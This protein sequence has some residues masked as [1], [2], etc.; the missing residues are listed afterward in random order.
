M[1]IVDKG[2]TLNKCTLINVKVFGE[3][4]SNTYS[5]GISKFANVV[6]KFTQ[7][8]NSNFFQMSS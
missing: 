3:D 6:I 5:S 4:T 1:E 8:N 2:M 7:F